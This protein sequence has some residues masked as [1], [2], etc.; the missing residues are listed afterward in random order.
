LIGAGNATNGDRRR[1]VMIE[2]WPSKPVSTPWE[3]DRTLRRS[4]MNISEIH[5]YKLIH[6]RFHGR[7][8][9]TVEGTWVLSPYNHQNKS[10]TPSPNGLAPVCQN[11]RP[12]HVIFE[13][14][15]LLLSISRLHLR[16]TGNGS[17]W[18]CQTVVWI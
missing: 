14:S 7:A 11:Q 4:F 17:W 10:E 15:E 12:C 18:T 13:R 8:R 1:A 5:S 6:I 2:K 3:W 9:I 16:S